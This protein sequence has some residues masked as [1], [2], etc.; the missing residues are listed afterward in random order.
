[1]DLKRTIGFPA[2][3][4]AETESQRMQLRRYLNLQLVALGLPTAMA[5][6]DAEFAEIAH[7]LLANYHE[8]TRLL[9]DHYSPVDQR[10]NDF[11]NVYFSDVD[12]SETMAVPSR[13]LVLDRHGLARELSLPA[14]GDEFI[15]DLVSS[16][17]LRN[18]VLHNPKHDRR[19]TKGTFHVCEGGLPIPADKKAVPKVT[20][21]RLFAAA[22]APPDEL[23]HLPFTYR[24]EESARSFVSLL[25]RPLVCPAV[26][27]VTPEKSMEVRFFVPGTLV[28]N[29]DFVESIFGNAG[30]PFIPENDAGLDIE[31]WTGTTGCV[32]LAPQMLQKTKRELGLPHVSEAT[33]RQ[34]RDGMC[35]ED[36]QELYND[37][38]PF[39]LTCRDKR[40]VIV[41]LIA[42]N[43][44]GYCKKEVKTQIS[45][46]AN[47][48]GNAEEEH[49]GGAIAFPSYDLGEEFQVNS[50]RYNG[51][52]FYDV[53]REFGDSIDVKPEGYGVDRVYNELVYIPEDAR[54]SLNDQQISWT[55]DGRRQSIPLIPGRIYMA[56]S[57]YKIQMEKHPTADTWHLIGT[58]AE[59]TFCHKPCTVSG[60]G[61]SEISKSLAD[62]MHYG[63]VFVSDLEKDLDA[64]GAILD[65]DFSTRHLPEYRTDGPSLGVLDPKRSLGSVIK[66]LTPSNRY[67]KEYNEWLSGIPNYVLALVFLIKRFH[68]PAIESDWRANFN[69]DIINGFPGH[70]LKYRDRKLVGGYLRVGLLGEH[71]WRTFKMRQ[72]FHPAAKIQTEDDISAS[73]VVPERHLSFLNPEYKAN[74]FKFVKNC[75]Y[76]LFQRP[77][78]A[79]HR[80]L[81]KQTELDLSQPGNFISNFEP[82]THD[83]VVEMT[84]YVADLDAFSQPMQDL[85]KKV[86]SGGDSY[87]VC[88]ANPR[89]VDGKPTKNPRYLQNRPDLVRPLSPYVAERGTRLFRAIPADN[90]VNMPVN[91]VLTGRRNNPPNPATGIRSLA[92]YNPIHYQEL[93]E[94][95]MDYISSLTGKSP[96]TT[97]A[98][99]EGALTKGPFNA[100]LP[101]ADLNTALVSS[102]LTGMAGFSTA[103]GH[104]GPKV[105]VDHDLSLLVPEVWCRMSPEERDPRFLI[106]EGQLEQVPDME[107]NGRK[108]LASRLGY[109]ITAP[110]VRT[111]FSRVFDNPNRVFD[112]EIL[113]PEKQDLD[114]FADGVVQI[115][116]AHERVARNYLEDGSLEQ[117][118]PPLKSLLQIMANGEDENG[119]D[120]QSPELRAM[121]TL[122]SML[123]SD[124]YRARLDTKRERDS[125]LW[126]RHIAY[127]E[128]FVARS[129]HT[130]ETDRLD[131]SSR[132]TFAREQLAAAESPQYIEDLVGMLGA[133]PLG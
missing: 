20:F 71:G 28:S 63:P 95:F 41:T 106:K 83:Q 16:Y 34:K 122:D 6:H 86:A 37:G 65:Y 64:V 60:G 92:V 7:G 82:I 55:R 81:D 121:F 67:T 113:R 1:M 42:D 88:S 56:P 75:E 18:G 115:M 62:Y 111:Y 74:S 96:S 49:A 27:D 10:I 103:A 105:R 54:A 69:V 51:R 117:A 66:L 59:G 127:A 72:D 133:D 94:L 33:D 48:F 126:R 61:K 43:Y 29:L 3:N 57:G 131:L 45:Y 129:S 52:T 84:R 87:V 90:D 102:L 114:A 85:L 2:G 89:Q 26:Q 5:P 77:D 50:R 132:L 119:W 32:I 68:R 22:M 36:P 93:P 39:K 130:A 110:F 21:K 104:I 14:D 13:S 108:I 125:A 15:S 9:H 76:R 12:E 31:H 53:A 58:V 100:L 120:A 128:S 24:S 91:S 47:L 109:R 30:D 23:L 118:C 8:K 116:E 17:R 46:S 38:Q 73:I 123:S 98:G 79:I 25:I 19:T 112:Q 35:W 44:Y 101:I 80:G 40:G 11:L 124:W 70:E 107:H 78:D 4:E 97:G 99:S